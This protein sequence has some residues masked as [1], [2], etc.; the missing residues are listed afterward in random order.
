MPG[1]YL[2][3]PLEA[4]IALAADP[5]ATFESLCV[6]TLDHSHA[7]SQRSKNGGKYPIWEDAITLKSEKQAP[8]ILELRGGEPGAALDLVGNA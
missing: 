6:V 7:E 5:S 8:C 4:K 2:I 3:K 1:T